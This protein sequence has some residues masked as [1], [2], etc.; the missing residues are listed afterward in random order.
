M[1]IS[2]ESMLLAYADDIEVMGEAR[3]NV[4]QTTVRLLK[5]SQ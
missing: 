3:E 2:G 5:T 1:E 4:V